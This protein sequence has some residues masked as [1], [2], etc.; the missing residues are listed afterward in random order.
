MNNSLEEKYDDIKNC[1]PYRNLACWGTS[2]EDSFEYVKIFSVTHMVKLNKLG[3]IIWLCID[4][5]TK[6]S[7]IIIKI[8]NLYADVAP[9]VIENDVISFLKE[10]QKYDMIILNWNPLEPYILKKSK[11][12]C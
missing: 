12:R 5:R 1:V 8:K 9:S 2:V 6:I 10:L 7:D 3:G 11:Y 4:G